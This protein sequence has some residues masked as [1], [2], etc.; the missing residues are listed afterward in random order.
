MD[1]DTIDG[2]V[3]PPRDINTTPPSFTDDD[4][5]RWIWHSE[6]TFNELLLPTNTMEQLE[7]DLSAASLAV[8]SAQ[9]RL[10]GL[11]EGP[12]R[13]TSGE[14]QPLVD[15]NTDGGMDLLVNMNPE[16]QELGDDLGARFGRPSDHSPYQNSRRSSVDTFETEYDPELGGNFQQAITGV[17]DLDHDQP[18]SR[19]SERSQEGMIAVEPATI[20][21]LPLSETLENS[22]EQD[23]GS[24]PN[25]VSQNLLSILQLPSF[26]SAPLPRWTTP[27]QW[28]QFQML[29]TYEDGLMTNG[30]QNNQSNDTPRKP[31]H[32]FKPISKVCS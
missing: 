18:P 10:E 23:N 9:E 26:I 5:H 15:S 19:T 14:N 17:E 29:R 30:T 22:Q 7:R 32:K 28:L 21:Q 4:V 20:T 27:P 16:E 25:L 24:E 12:D 2:E 8:E 1:L 11:R 31:A 13:P 3:D 6:A